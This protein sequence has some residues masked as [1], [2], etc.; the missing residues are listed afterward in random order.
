MSEETEGIVKRFIEECLNRRDLDLVNQLFSPDYVNYAATQDISPDLEGYKQRIAYMFTSFPDLHVK[1]EDIFSDE[2][3]VGI[4]LTA[5]GSHMGDLMGFSATGRYAEW[6]AI[7]IYQVSDGK[8]LKR[9]ENR[10]DLG[11]MEQLAIGAVP[12]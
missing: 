9:W 6:T 1:I 10:D 4:R 7:A 12:K 3:K 2:D 5:S 8:I 11:L